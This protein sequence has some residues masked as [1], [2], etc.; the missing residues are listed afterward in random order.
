MDRT[1]SM[2]EFG[3]KRNAYSLLVKKQGKIG[4]H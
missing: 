1:C 4:D 3:V 2:H